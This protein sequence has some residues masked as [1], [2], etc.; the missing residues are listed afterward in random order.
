MLFG[1]AAIACAA[2]RCRWD[3]CGGDMEMATPGWHSHGGGQDLV[4]GVSRRWSCRSGSPA[5]ALGRPVRPVQDSKGLRSELKTAV[6]Q[7]FPVQ[8][9]RSG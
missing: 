6:L 2:A 1:S 8:N 3:R 4:D 7:Y 5:L 9:D